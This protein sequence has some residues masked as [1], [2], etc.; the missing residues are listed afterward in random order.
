MEYNF[1][2]NYNEVTN[3]GINQQKNTNSNVQLLLMFEIID[4]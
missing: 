1:L 2:R 4:I 3:E